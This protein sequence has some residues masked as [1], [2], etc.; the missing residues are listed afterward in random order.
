MNTARIAKMSMPYRPEPT[1]PNTISPSAMLSIAMPPA[2]GVRLSWLAL[3]APHD[4]AVVEFANT[5]VCAMPKRT[6]LPSMLPPELPAV[7]A[8][9]RAG[10]GEVGV[11]DVL[12]RVDRRH[13]DREQD[14][15]RGQEHPP[16]PGVARE[17]P[18]HVRKA[19]GNQQ[20]RE[21][22]QQVGERRGVLE[23]MR[24]VGVEEAAAVGAEL[25]D[26]L[27]GRDRALGRW[28]AMRPRRS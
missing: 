16:L 28:S 7:A 23:R 12:E 13:A 5:A 22:L 2:S 8:C 20:D 15:H 10:L 6:S 19:R 25:L 26:R 27:L 17:L 1:P 18:D 24:R 3:T 14:R 4:A 9:D 11:A 21:D